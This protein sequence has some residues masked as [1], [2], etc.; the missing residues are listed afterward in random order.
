MRIAWSRV[1]VR[2]QKGTFL[3]FD[4]QASAPRIA[5][6]EAGFVQTVVIAIWHQSVRQ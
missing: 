4:N 6:K 2:A 1:A 5:S 3:T